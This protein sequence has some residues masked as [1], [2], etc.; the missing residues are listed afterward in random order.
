MGSKNVCLR[1]SKVRHSRDNTVDRAWSDTPKSFKE[2]FLPQLPGNKTSPNLK[3]Q[4]THHAGQCLELEMTQVA[5][6]SSF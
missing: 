6:H 1:L 2:P 5:S 4:L 3:P